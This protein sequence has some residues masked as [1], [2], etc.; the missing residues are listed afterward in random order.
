MTG[1]ISRFSVLII[2]VGAF[3]F[4]FSLRAEAS[5]GGLLSACGGFVSRAFTERP[6]APA[7]DPR[8]P[9]GPEHFPTSTAI[10]RRYR[11]AAT[12]YALV[13]A[14]IANEIARSFSMGAPAG[15]L[16]SFAAKQMTLLATELGHDKLEVTRFFGERRNYPSTAKLDL[17]NI[18]LTGRHFEGEGIPRRLRS[19]LLS[20]FVEE[21]RLV[22]ARAGSLSPEFINVNQWTDD[23]VGG[24]VT[25]YET[26][27]AGPLEGGIVLRSIRH[28][29]KDTVFFSFPAPPQANVILGDALER[30]D[31]LATTPML[32]A[33][34]RQEFITALY[35]YL[36]AEPFGEGGHEIGMPAFAGF[37]K[38][39]T[40]RRMP[41]IP[42]ASYLFSRMMLGQEA[43]VEQL[44]PIL[45]P[46][47][48]ERP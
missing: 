47:G 13:Q 5:F 23:F 24:K 28:E 48:N 8:H 4:S 14:Q 41:S 27:E 19:R 25:Q 7:D 45:F 12:A 15:E 18:D 17:I 11:P 46:S 21:F 35:G 30:L 6:W 43:F 3:E 26:L 42:A 29:W 40:G 34:I 22:L 36:Q 37:Y 1:N 10:H 32:P 2:I 33:A 16:L 31:N 38:G 9:Y 39:L 20:L 44:E